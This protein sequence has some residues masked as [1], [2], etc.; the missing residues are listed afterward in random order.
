MALSSKLSN[1]QKLLFEH[2]QT[3]FNL[4]D[5]L[6]FASDFLEFLSDNKQAVIVSQNEN[7]YNFF[8]FNKSANF[9][10][11]RPFN[12]DLIL[13]FDDFD[14]KRIQFENDINI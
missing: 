5:F 4:N 12:H 3:F 2:K 6:D 1:L 11:T 14:K 7:N 13:D 8:Q 9:A 10:V